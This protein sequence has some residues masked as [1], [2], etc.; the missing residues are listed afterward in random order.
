MTEEEDLCFDGRAAEIQG[1]LVSSDDD[2]NDGLTSSGLL[3]SMGP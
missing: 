2:H 1:G 3:H